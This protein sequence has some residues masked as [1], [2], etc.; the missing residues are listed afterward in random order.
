M[1]SHG[2]LNIIHQGHRHSNHAASEISMPRIPRNVTSV[3]YFVTF[4]ALCKRFLMT[5]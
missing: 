1:I 5:C 2:S 4:P 3:C